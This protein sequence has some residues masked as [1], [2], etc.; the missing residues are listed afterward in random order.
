MRALA[1]VLPRRN[2]E[3]DVEEVDLGAPRGDEVLVRLEACGICHAD[4][5]ANH[6]DL[7][8]PA[9]G[10]LGHEGAGV[11]IDLGPDARRTSVGERVVLGMPWCGCCER[12]LGGQPR[13]CD[14]VLTLI[15]RGSRADG[16]TS[17]AR[18]DGSPLHSHFFGQ[19]SFSTHC[20]V[21]EGQAVAVPDDLPLDLAAPL[22][23]GIS[24]GAGAVLNVL[25]PPAGSSL[26]VFGVGTVG[27]AAVMAA[28]NSGVSR[29]VAVDRFQSRLDAARELGASETLLADGETEVPYVV[30]EICGGPADF[31]L[32]CTG[33]MRVLRDAVESIGML[34][35]CGLIGGAAAGAEFT[36]DHHSTMIGKRIVGIH[37][38]EGT[39]RSLIGGLID[40]HRHGRLPFDR[41]V[42]HFELEDVNE[43]ITASDRGEVIKAVL[44]MPS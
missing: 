17:L 16:S 14:E 22:G 1:A 19:S 18:L 3:L 11:V 23:C 33:N 28:Q 6:G 10:V 40:L 44:R 13:Y 21:R 29:I 12:C 39:S 5:L 15:T 27:L 38:G 43:A 36:L 35:V 4:S 2:A 42:E 37:G 20:L 8:F 30:R 41:L 25:R 34:G 24:T 7:P 9:P 32:E 26:V 31:A